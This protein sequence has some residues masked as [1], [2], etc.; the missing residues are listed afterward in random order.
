MKSKIVILGSSIIFLLLISLIWFTT[1]SR[2]IISTQIFE[3][4]EIALKDANKDTLVI[5]DVD[6]VLIMPT[7]QGFQRPMDENFLDEISLDL[8]TRL[9][10]EK[11]ELLESIILLQETDKFV[12][13]KIISLIKT[14]QIKGVPVMAL[15]ALSTGAYGKIQSLVDWRIL[16]LETMGIN[17]KAPWENVQTKQFS[18]FDI[19]DLKGLPVFKAGILFSSKIPKGEALHAFLQYAKLKPKKIIFIDD[20]REHVESVQKVC[21]EAGIE[22]VGFEYSGAYSRSEPLN[23]ARVRF[24]YEVLEK[25]HKWLSDYE[26]DRRLVD[27][28]N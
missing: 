28:K 19:K 22:F 1:N 6:D 11:T 27:S 24:L 17:L 12:D 8:K 7:N 15:T 18:D 16:K 23:K 3:P 26:A 5:F 4:I 10:E 25:E 20:F 21:N 9:G 13:P 14:L 2:E